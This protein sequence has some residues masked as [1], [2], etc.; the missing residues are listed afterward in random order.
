MSFDTLVHG[1]TAEKT[2]PRGA[3]AD[4]LEQ[5]LSRI[6]SDFTIEASRLKQIVARFQ[7]ELE[8]GKDQQDEYFLPVL[9]HSRTTT[10]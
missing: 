2:A 5:N 10:R 9:K 7:E 3:Q 4:D 6:E 1:R 8:D